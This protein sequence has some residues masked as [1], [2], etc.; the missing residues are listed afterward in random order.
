MKKFLVLGVLFILPIVAYVFFAS[1]VN[2]FSRLPVLTEEIKEVNTFKSLSGE[3]ITLK[4]KITVL[5]FLGSNPL[6]KKGNAF[7]LNQKIYKRFYQF[8]DFQFVMVLP[9]GQEENAKALKKELDFLTDTKNW[10]FI[11]GSEEQ[12]NALFNS[13]NTGLV[14]DNEMSLPEVF[15][16]DKERNLRGRNGDELLYGFDT[17]RVSELH[18]KMVDDVKVL[19]SEYRLAL[20]KNNKYREK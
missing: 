5:G 11:F 7:N 17:T 18:N 2:N 3:D 12:V 8:D 9:L 4:N 6:Q 10:K 14:L 1:G 20:K 13:L 15:I 19:L 16:I